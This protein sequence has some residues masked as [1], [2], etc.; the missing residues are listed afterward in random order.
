[1][2]EIPIAAKSALSSTEPWL[3]VINQAIGD[4]PIGIRA[5]ALVV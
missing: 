4:F 1:M 5:T 3:E 2:Q